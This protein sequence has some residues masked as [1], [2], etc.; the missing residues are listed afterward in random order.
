M[1]C[2]LHVQAN[3]P[4]IKQL[5]DRERTVIVAN[6]NDLQIFAIILFAILFNWMLWV[7]SSTL[8]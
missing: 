1:A 4:S 3:A 5:I 2:R 8:R 7:F 6:E